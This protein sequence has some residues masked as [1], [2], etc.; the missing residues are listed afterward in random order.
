[1]LKRTLASIAGRLG[2]EIR[3]KP[4][5]LE[6][7]PDAQAYRPLFCPW[8]AD[9]AFEQTIVGLQDKTLVTVDRLHVLYTL[10]RQAARLAGEFWECGVFRGGT[11][12]LLARVLSDLQPRGTRLRLFDTFQ[13]MPETDPARDRHRQGDFSQTDLQRVKNLLPQ[14]FVA[15][16]PGTIPH[17][18]ADLGRSRLAFVHLD[19]DIYGSYRDCLEF[20]Y[21]R[22]VPG[23]FIVCDDY[24]FPSCPGARRA[25]D[26]FF[27]HR[28]ER[29]LILGTGQAVIVKMP[30]AEERS[31]Q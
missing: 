10:A 12:L 23:G 1:M 20:V 30:V 13:G 18:F 14:P 25:T 4:K 27:A 31:C 26:E 5:P 2:Y 19:V 9:R 16:H 7:I 8:I 11:A 29:P 22:L 6:G 3:R 28:P 21:P 15:F 24:G 17:T